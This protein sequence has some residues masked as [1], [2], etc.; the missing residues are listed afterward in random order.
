MPARSA[1]IRPCTPRPD[2]P[3]RFP[4]SRGLRRT[5]MLY[6]GYRYYD[7][8]S[9]RWASRDPIGEEGGINLY[10]PCANSLVRSY[11]G[12]G[13]A[14]S[15]DDSTCEKLAESLGGDANSEDVKGAVR[16]LCCCS[17]LYRQLGRQWLRSH[18][19]K[20]SIL[21]VTRQTAVS[22]YDFRGAESGMST[23]N[24][25]WIVVTGS[26]PDWLALT[27]G[28]EMYHDLQQKTASRGLVN[29]EEERKRL[30]HDVPDASLRKFAADNR[31]WST[32][33]PAKHEDPSGAAW[34][35]SDFEAR[36]AER[37]IQQQ[38]VKFCNWL[39]EK[40][41]TR[42]TGYRVFGTDKMPI[43]PFK[44]GSALHPSLPVATPY[45]PPASK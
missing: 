34:Y 31:T 24:N 11:D 14:D 15:S 28:H 38:A 13:T 1:R 23:P 20:D 10:S 36:R 6:Y 32:H 7:A 41:T 33:D 43:P 9:G 25:K 42:Y 26:V 40:D 30:E 8:V 35:M 12:L 5:M 21:V 27:I 44:K 22:Q 3:G 39:P 2:R 37:V 4:A 17:E 18:P 19:G 45:E 29:A 16:R